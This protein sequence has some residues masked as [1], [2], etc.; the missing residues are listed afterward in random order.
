MSNPLILLGLA[1][2]IVAP[3]IRQLKLMRLPFYGIAVGNE[4]IVGSTVGRNFKCGSRWN[5][6]LLRHA[7]QAVCEVSEFS[8]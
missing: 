4:S 7:D 3:G 2:L 6:L 5:R 8:C 1:L